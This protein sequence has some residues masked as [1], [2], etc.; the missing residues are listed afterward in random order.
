MVEITGFCL[1][2]DGSVVGNATVRYR[3]A[4]MAT[5]SSGTVYMPNVNEV[6]TDGT[7]G[8]WSIEVPENSSVILDLP[9]RPESLETPRYRT[10]I[11]EV[12]DTTPIQFSDD[13]IV[14]RY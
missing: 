13:I 4:D 12:E 6:L 10:Y 3:I 2:S 1:N 9:Y 14:D 11:I 7:T 8:Y 5:I